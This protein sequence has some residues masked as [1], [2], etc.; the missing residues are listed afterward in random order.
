MFA[1]HLVAHRG[2]PTCLPEN[3]LP[4]IEATLQAGA[5]YVEVDIQ[6][7]ADGEPVLFH[8]RD[9]QRL[10]QQPGAIYDY[11]LAELR[12]F[13]VQ[14]RQRFADS[15]DGL[16]IPHLDELVA[17]LQRQPAV[18]V[19][20]E[21]KRVSLEHFGIELVV[22]R[23]LSALQAVA[24]QVVI[25]SYNLEALQQVKGGSD[26]PI[27]A[28]FDDWQQHR[29]PGITRLQAE[30]L[31][32]DIASLPA[33]GEVSVAGSRVAVYECTDPQQALAVWRRGVSLVGT[34]AIG[35]MLAQLETM[36]PAF[37]F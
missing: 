11:R 4:S 29:L 18:T 27:G 13:Q 15:T 7:S 25:I 3:T 12:T 33:E 10:C 26:L 17:L 36:E 22:V 31:F 32:C 2:Y 24:N 30:Y 9:L 34:F 6:L 37:E 21:L 20:I 5:R 28:V 16:P 19:F 8:D 23:V 14:D 35:E 1:D